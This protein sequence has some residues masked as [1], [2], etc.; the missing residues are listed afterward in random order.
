MQIQLCP[1]LYI[2]N[3]LQEQN[4]KGLSGMG[5]SVGT[6]DASKFNEVQLEVTL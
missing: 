1:G 5:G 6:F 4:L 3:I 2:E